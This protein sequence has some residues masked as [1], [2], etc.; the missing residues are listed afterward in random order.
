MKTKLFLLSL[1]LFLSVTCHAEKISLLN[2][3][4]SATA[5]LQGAQTNVGGVVTFKASPKVT[6][7]TATLLSLIAK[8]EYNLGNW[9]SNSF[10]KGAKI[11]LYSDNVDYE[12]NFFFVADKNNHF[13]CDASDVLSWS[14]PGNVY[15]EAGKVNLNTGLATGYSQT[16][17][18]DI[19]FSDFAAGGW[20]SF[21]LSGHLV[22]GWTDT[23]NAKAHTYS[24]KE[25]ITFSSGNGEGFVNGTEGIFSGSASLSATTV[26]P[27]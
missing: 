9:D 8:A 27:L 21:S 25:T 22:D 2:F 5:L 17:I 19:D 26:F 3:T 4:F 16:V 11:L 15:V 10:P 7:T 12:N 18:F 13:L 23:V 6:L 24:E 20:T 14:L 1:F